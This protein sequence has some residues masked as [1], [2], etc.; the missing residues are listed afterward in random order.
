MP[1]IRRP[2]AFTV[3]TT[4]LR[5]ALFKRLHLTVAIQRKLCSYRARALSNFPSTTMP[6]IEHVARL[7]AYMLRQ[8]VLEDTFLS[9][10]GGALSTHEF[11]RRST[12]AVFSRQVNYLAALLQEGRGLDPENVKALDW[13]CG[14]GQITYLLRQKGLMVTS[15]DL[16]SNQDDSAF[17]QEVPILQKLAVSVVPLEDAV[18]LPFPSK[19]FD[20][21]V[22]FGV[23]EHVKSDTESLAEIRRILKPGGILFIV[24]LPYFLSWTQAIARVRGDSY[25]DR[26]YSRSSINR[27]AEASGFIPCGLRHAQ[28]FP[29]NSVPLKFDGW[30]EPIDRLLCDYTPLKYFATNLELVMVAVD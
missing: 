2:I 22:S 17:G 15:C 10:V 5:G 6:A 4:S 14:K 27:L 24:F 25:H 20:C 28:L 30:L 13:G 21:V 1:K 7:R 11:L 9:K 12:Q 8:P 26:L 29:K 3:L 16:L 23:L 18:R 19:N